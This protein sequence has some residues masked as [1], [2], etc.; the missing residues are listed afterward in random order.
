MGVSSLKHPLV[1]FELAGTKPAR[2]P[3]PTQ[4]AGR[5][6]PS[7]TPLDTL[8]PKHKPCI[9]KALTSHQR[10]KNPKA[11]PNSQESPEP[12]PSTPTPETLYYTFIKTP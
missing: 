2:T 1:G 4:T 7:T 5:L 6:Q 8:S 3:L 9:P 11:A 10:N 12:K